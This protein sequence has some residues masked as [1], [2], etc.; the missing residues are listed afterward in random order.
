[1]EGW[2]CVVSLGGAGG[3]GGERGERGRVAEELDVCVEER[4]GDGG[5][6]GREDL[7]VHDECLR[8]VA[9][10]GVVGLSAR[11]EHAYAA[12]EHQ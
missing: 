5:P 2:T 4:A 3:E 8:C 7:F 11:C 12:S 9:C 6:D 1:M 10:G